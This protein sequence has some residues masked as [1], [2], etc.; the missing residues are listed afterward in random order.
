[1][2]KQLVLLVT[3]IF[4]SAAAVAQN[5]QT[6]A[7]AQLYRASGV[8]EGEI[9]EA[10]YDPESPVTHHLSDP[11]GYADTYS[12]PLFGTLKAKATAAGTSDGYGRWYAGSGA[13]FQDTWT[14]EA[15]GL[16]GRQGFIIADLVFDRSIS[17]AG[18]IVDSYGAIAMDFGTNLSR[19]SLSEIALGTLNGVQ[20]TRV[21]DFGFEVNWLTPTFARASIPI[22]FGADTLF[23]ASVQV[24]ALAG[25]YQG[26]S[27]WSADASNSFYWGGIESVIDEIGNPVSFTLV[28]ASGTDYLVSQVPVPEPETYALFVAGLGVLGVSIRRK[29]RQRS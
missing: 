3:S 18:S 2:Q 6:T 11:Y 14:V 10:I 28:S 19:Y 23:S 9:N 25:Y 17:Y 21:E 7:I 29:K 16:V 4:L 12:S 15:K 22:T 26:S 1:M 24:S 5:F 20:T 13:A 8:F 27:L